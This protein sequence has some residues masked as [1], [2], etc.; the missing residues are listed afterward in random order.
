MSTDIDTRFAF[1]ERLIREAGAIALEYF[2]RVAEL[3]VNSKGPQDMVS[4]ADV[5]VEKLIKAQLAAEFPTDAFLGEETG[6]ADFPD[7]TGIWV[8]DPIDGTQ[9]FVN[10]LSTWCVSIAYVQGTDIRLGLVF[11]PVADEL[12]TGGTGLPAQRNGRPIH[13]HPGTSLAD[14]LLFLGCSTRVRPDQV[15]PVLDR[16]LHGG[17]MFIRN[18]SGALGLCDVACGRLLGYVEPHINSWDCL[19]AIA[20]LRSAGAQVNDFLTGDALLQGNEIVA[21]PP[22][23]FETVYHLLHD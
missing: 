10:G 20:V 7:S 19:G 1:A 21:A 9:P 12:F 5:A 13:P 15:V 4:E 3:E 22:A 16:L 18:G 2:H 14:G 23:L 6:H 17:G 8:V 11:N